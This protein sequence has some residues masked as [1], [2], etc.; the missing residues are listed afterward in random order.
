MGHRTQENSLLTRLPIYFKRI[1]LRNS[2]VEEMQGKVLSIGHRPSMLS[3]HMPPSRVF[4][5]LEVLRT[6]PVRI[7]MKVRQE[8]GESQAEQPIPVDR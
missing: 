8:I 1:Q 4:S 7:I 2:Q 6:F 3:L 5:N